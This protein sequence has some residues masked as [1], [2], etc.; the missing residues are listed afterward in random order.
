MRH[1]S[2]E[3]LYSAGHHWS[4]YSRT[5]AT[6]AKT[7]CRPVMTSPHHLHRLP[8]RLVLPMRSM[9]QSVNLSYLKYFSSNYVCHRKEYFFWL[10]IN[11]GIKFWII[12]GQQKLLYRTSWSSGYLTVLCINCF[13]IRVL[14]SSYISAI[15]N[16]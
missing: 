16:N 12:K 14:Y 11:F 8:S 1:S 4:L 10:T 5:S 2:T 6:S 15:N 7:V 13:A 3:E 9:T